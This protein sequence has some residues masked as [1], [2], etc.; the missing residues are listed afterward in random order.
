MQL[1]VTTSNINSVRLRA[2]NIARFLRKEKPDV[3][4]L[5]ETKCPDDQFPHDVFDR[6][7]YTHRLIHGMKSYNGVA[8]ISRVPF[9]G[10]APAMNALLAGQV[11]YVCDPIL[12]PLPHVRAGTVKAHAIATAKRHPALPDVPTAAEGGLP[13]F[14]AA[15]FYAVFAPK[16]T[17]QPV[18]DRLVAALDTALHRSRDAASMRQVTLA[19]CVTSSIACRSARHSSA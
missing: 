8:I 9:T 4:C 19:F 7:G 11:D 5:Q 10:T 1:K 13:Q 15:P 2:R 18:L 14:S 16:G 12:G 17:P 6:L 3:L